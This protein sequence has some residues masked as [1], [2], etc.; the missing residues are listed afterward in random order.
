MY[1]TSERGIIFGK[2]NLTK[3]TIIIMISE[4]EMGIMMKNDFYVIHLGFGNF[5]IYHQAKRGCLR[6]FNKII[7]EME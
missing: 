2:M 3:M 7:L 1:D 5:T 4:D 6:I